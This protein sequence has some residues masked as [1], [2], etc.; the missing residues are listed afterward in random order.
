MSNTQSFYR[1]VKKNMAFTIPKGKTW[2]HFKGALREAERAAQKGN[3][4]GM[5]DALHKA[6]LYAIPLGLTFSQERRQRIV[7]A[8]AKAMVAT[9]EVRVADS[10]GDVEKHFGFREY[11]ELLEQGSLREGSMVVIVDGSGARYGMADATTYV[12]AEGG[13]LA[14]QG[15]S[16]NPRKVLQ[17]IEWLVKKEEKPT[18]QI[19]AR[20]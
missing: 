11:R 5:Y 20:G 10:I 19:F 3:E 12:V 6:E 15:L 17:G 1:E 18:E 7:D 14:R 9:A 8:Y 16:M 4:D 2:Q 13:K